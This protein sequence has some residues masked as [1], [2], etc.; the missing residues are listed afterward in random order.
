MTRLGADDEIDVRDLIAIAHKGFAQREISCHDH[1]LRTGEKGLLRTPS[2][3]D[4]LNPSGVVGPH[5]RVRFRET[6][7]T[8]GP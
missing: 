5:S 1:Y 2:R 4:S 6:H 7:A 3:E 8:G